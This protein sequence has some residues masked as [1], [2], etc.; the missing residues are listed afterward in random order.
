[1][2]IAR[3]L[4]V[5]KRP[6]CNGD[7][8]QQIGTH[9]QAGILSKP[10]NRCAGGHAMNDLRALHLI[11]STIKYYQIFGATPEIRDELLL[12]SRVTIQWV[13]TDPTA[14]ARSNELIKLSVLIKPLSVVGC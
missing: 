12:F 3:T 11:H 8:S 14:A 6:S 13:M 2:A 7:Y 1:V 10:V 4:H 5:A 9:S